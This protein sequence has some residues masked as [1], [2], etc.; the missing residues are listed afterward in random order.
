MVENIKTKQLVQKY[1]L[2]QVLKLKILELIETE[3]RHE[4][5]IAEKARRHEI[6]LDSDQKAILKIEYELSSRRNI[7]QNEDEIEKVRKAF[8]KLSKQ[9]K[10]LLRLIYFEG[11]SERQVAQFYH[12]YHNAIH[13]R[14]K[15]ILKKMKK[16]F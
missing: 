11:N 9:D 8:C 7:T 14:K 3:E 6:S 4:R 5:W 10:E 12:V 1:V 13:K 15:R 16:V 2:D